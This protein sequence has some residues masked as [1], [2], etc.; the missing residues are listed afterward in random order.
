MMGVVPVGAAWV[1]VRNGDLDLVAL[2]RLHAT[3]DIVRIAAG[4]DVQTMHVDVRGVEVMRQ[5]GI[6]RHL[7]AVRR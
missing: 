2:P 1:V 3:E 5:V 6:E 4:T 7:R